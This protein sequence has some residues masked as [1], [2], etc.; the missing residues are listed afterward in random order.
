MNTNIKSRKKVME[1]L[2]DISRTK[3]IELEKEYGWTK[4]TLGNDGRLVYYDIQEV[5]T[6]FRK[7]KAS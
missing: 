6:S 5:L 1:M 7:V 4:Y 2:G 3:C